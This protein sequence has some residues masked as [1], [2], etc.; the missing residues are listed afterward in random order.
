MAYEFPSRVAGVYRIMTTVLFFLLV[1]SLLDVPAV[2]Q[3]NG[4][5][6]PGPDVNPERTR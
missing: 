6:S 4:D 1:L 2:H 5:A 3:P